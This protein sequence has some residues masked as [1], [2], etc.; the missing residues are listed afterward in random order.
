MRWV[1]VYISLLSISAFADLD[2]DQRQGIQDT[3]HLL[4]T[5]A[6]R[7]KAIAHDPKAKEIDD[8][9]GALAG[10]AQNK[11]EMYDLAAQLVEK[12]AAQANGDPEKMQQLMMEAQKDP[13]AFYEKFFDDKQ[14]A[15]VRGLANKIE[16]DK[17]GI[18]AK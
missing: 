6:A 18:P 16:G 5:P 2:K 10:S 14:K 8:K 1:L 4:K 7:A 12:V 13:K 17:P 15:K 9:A 11:D 3:Q